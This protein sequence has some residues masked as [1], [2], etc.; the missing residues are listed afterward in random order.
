[1]YD[2]LNRL[3]KIKNVIPAEVFPSEAR[4]IIKKIA[5][6]CRETELYKYWSSKKR[7]S[8]LENLDAKILYAKM[9]EKSRTAADIAPLLESVTIIYMPLLDDKLNKQIS[10]E[11]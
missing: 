7:K 3:Y 4:K 1:M 11:A 10:K 2:D 6:E 5:D 9:I 8:S